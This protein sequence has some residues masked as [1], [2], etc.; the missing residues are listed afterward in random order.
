VGSTKSNQGKTQGSQDVVKPQQPTANLQYAPMVFRLYYDTS[1][2]HSYEAGQGIRGIQILFTNEA[3]AGASPEQILT[4][5]EGLGS[6]KLSVQ[7]HRIVIPYLGVNMPLT[8]F[9]SHELHSLWLPSVK[10]P[11]R[12]P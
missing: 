1:G 3:T 6:L 10:L 11:D 8:A 4:V 5:G 9:P 2:T 12:V 7:S